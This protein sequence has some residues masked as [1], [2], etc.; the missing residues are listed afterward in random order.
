MHYVGLWKTYGQRMVDV[1]VVG[2]VVESELLIGCLWI[3]A[4]CFVSAAVLPVECFGTL[5]FSD[6]GRSRWGVGE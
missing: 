5:V 4:E 3:T 6:V 1:L 2:L